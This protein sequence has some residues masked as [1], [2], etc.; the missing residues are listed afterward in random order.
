MRERRK[1]DARVTAPSQLS[2]TDAEST[3]VKKLQTETRNDTHIIQIN[4]Q[5]NNLAYFR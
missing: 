2:I 4:K 3:N 5:E 1:I